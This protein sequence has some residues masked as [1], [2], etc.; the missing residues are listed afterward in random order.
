MARYQVI[1][2]YDG[3]DFRGMQRQSQTRTV[4]GEVE[5]A[6]RKIGWQGKSILAAGRTDSGV[7]ASGQVIAF[8]LKW[9]HSPE[10]LLKALNANLP[11]EVAS[12]SLK[13]VAEEFHPRYDAVSRHYQFHIFCQPQRDPLR[14]RYAWRVWPEI[15]IGRMQVAADSLCG[16]HDFSAFGAATKPDG[17]TVRQVFSTVWKQIDDELTFEIS[18]NAF[19]YHMVRRIVRLLVEIGQNKY[20]P[21]IVVD[22]LHRKNLETSLGL[23]PPNGLS[24]MEVR[25]QNGV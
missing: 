8:D 15:K 5:Q 16:E 22:F 10:K 21:E 20:E 25:Y 1:L 7:H 4:Q 14:E 17:P 24:L 2:A 3:T 23:A 13:Q 11:L 9:A 19:L 12:T 6:L 18:A